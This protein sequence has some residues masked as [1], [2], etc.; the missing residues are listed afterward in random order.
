M[1]LMQL[2]YVSTALVELDDAEL[3]TLAEGAARFN[4]AHGLTGMLLYSRGGFLQVLEGEPQPL[5]EAW[6][7]I[8]RDPR[9]YGLIQLRYAPLAS[10]DFGQWSMGFHMLD[11]ADRLRHAALFP[12][13]VDGFDAGL[14]GAKPGAAL[15][16]LSDFARRW[17]PLSAM[18]SA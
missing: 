7:R 13:G 11:E 12:L 15:N 17:R 14:L 2:I 1:A 3:A 4:G 5:A 6:R 9:H 10:R 18:R 8:R 16:L